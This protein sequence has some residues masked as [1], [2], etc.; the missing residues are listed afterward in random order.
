MRGR[1]VVLLLAAVLAACAR[2]GLPEGGPP[3][4]TPPRVLATQPDS[5]AT[6]VPVDADVAITFSEPMNRASVLDWVL[7]SP[8]R[9]FGK[10]GWKGNTFHLGGGSDFAPDV[11]TTVVVGIGCRDDRE[12]NTLAA[13]YLFV[14]STGDS[15]DQG[16]IEGR[17]LAK[18]Q[19]AHGTMV[20]AVDIQHAASH[21]DT[22]LPDYITQAA[23]DSSFVFIGLKAGRRYRVMAHFDPNHDREFDRDTDFL[24]AYP[25]TL[26]LDPTRPLVSGVAIDYRDPRAPGSIA[27]TVIDS[28]GAGGLAAPPDTTRSV[29]PDTTRSAGQDTT[30][31]ARR[32]LW[33]EAWLRARAVPP[34]EGEVELPDTTAAGQTQPDS[35]GAFEI[36]NLIPGLYRVQAFLDRDGDRRYDAGEPT[37]ES[38]DSVRVTPLEKTGG[39]R[40]V[41][42]PA[43]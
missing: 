18:G 16:R 6:R 9:D 24:A 38:A 29:H 33:V 11:T 19:T 5:G 21:P 8:P 40:L 15:L 30:R 41:V 14:F 20:W 43:R 42:R 25:D 32:P 34:R 12:G 27:G 26:W 7:L 1:S 22:L 13:P 31:T 4:L 28:T 37:S 2:Q 10:R 17:L 39:L 3:D 36:R 35:L 23:T